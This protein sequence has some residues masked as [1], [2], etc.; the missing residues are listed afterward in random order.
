MRF[1]C[2]IL[3]AVSIAFSKDDGGH[4]NDMW[5]I[6]PFDESALDAENYNI[7]ELY[8]D[9]NSF[10]DYCEYPALIKNSK[11]IRRE[12]SR[13]Q[14]LFK[15]SRYKDIDYNCKWGNHRIWFHWGFFNSS[16]DSEEI[17]K[18]INHSSCQLAIKASG[19]DVNKEMDLLFEKRKRHL[20][21][22]W[23]AVFNTPKCRSMSTKK[24][25]AF[26]SLLYSIHILGDYTNIQLAELQPKFDLYKSIRNDILTIGDHS[27]VSKKFLE[28]I[29]LKS[30]RTP[31]ATEL[32]N[33]LSK[34]F[35]PFL[36]DLAKERNDYISAFGEKY[37]LKSIE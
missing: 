4:S 27:A 31:S 17:N 29:G 24:K 14:E 18:K 7:Q 26:V 36:Y 3:L 25:E 22:W 15:D 34:E 16:R 2:I 19:I 6:F 1:F 12:C 20:M 35:T 37:K 30:L 9:I 23:D 28:K 5:S 8:K 33:N 11:P 10:L 13:L 32:L 21:K